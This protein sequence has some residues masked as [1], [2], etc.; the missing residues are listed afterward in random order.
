MALMLLRN[1]AM[2]KVKFTGVDL[3]YLAKKKFQ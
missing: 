2:Q 3:A 1:E